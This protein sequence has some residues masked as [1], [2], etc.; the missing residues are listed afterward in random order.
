MVVDET[1]KP[2]GGVEI[3]IQLRTFAKGAD[4]PRI[5]EYGK[6]KTDPKGRFEI[7]SLHAVWEIEPR[8]GFHLTFSTPAQFKDVSGKALEN[9]DR[10][11]SFVLNGTSPANKPP[12]FKRLRWQE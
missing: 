1:G 3:M 8:S 9:W 12:V 4:E 2:L 11:E 7:K 5:E 6:T 10:V